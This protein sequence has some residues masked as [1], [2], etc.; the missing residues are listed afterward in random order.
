MYKNMCI[1]FLT[2][3]FIVFITT[4][5]EW[6]INHLKLEGPITIVKPVYDSIHGIGLLEALNPVPSEISREED[7]DEWCK[8]NWGTPDEAKV[9]SLE[10]KY[11]DIKSGKVVLRAGFKT[12]CIP[13]LK[14]YEAFIEKYGNNECSLVASY[15]NSS[16]MFCGEYTNDKG[17]CEFDIDEDTIEGNGIHTGE[18]RTSE[19]T[20]CFMRLDDL[21]GIRGIWDEWYNQWLK[22]EGISRN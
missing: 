20:E 16:D 13:P 18:V 8:Q 7:W 17:L 9:G 2:T 5:T 3:S 6:C 14:A 22:E 4:M 1:T 19:R 10:L 15:Y 21:F 11:M 12:D